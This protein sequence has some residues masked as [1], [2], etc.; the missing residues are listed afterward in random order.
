MFAHNLKPEYLPWRRPKCDNRISDAN[1]PIVFRSNYGS[2]LLNF[3]DMAMERAT[4]GRTDDGNHC[5]SGPW[6]SSNKSVTFYVAF[7]YIQIHT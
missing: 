6:R 4:D 5:I 1:F 7:V 3:R 2:I